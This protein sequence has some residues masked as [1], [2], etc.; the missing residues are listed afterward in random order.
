MRDILIVEDDGVFAEILKNFLE[1]QRYHCFVAK[2]LKAA[3]QRLRSTAA[4]LILLDLNLPDGNGLDFLFDLSKPGSQQCKVVVMTSFNDVR[5]AVQALKSGAYE[6]I[7]KPVNPDELLMIVEELKTETSTGN[8]QA[9]SSTPFITG[10][11]ESSR[12]M[13]T[14]IRL[15]AQ[16]NLTVLLEGKS[17]T[18]KEKAAQQIHQLSKRANR[19]FVAVDCGVLNAETANSE[20]FGHLKGS[21]TGAIQDKI[22]HIQYADGGTLFLDEIGNLSY[23]VQVK[24][25]RALQERVIQPMGSNKPHKVDLRIIA[26][27]NEDLRKAINRGEFREDLYHRINEFKIAV[28]S[29]SERKEDLAMLI[30]YFIGQGNRELNKSVRGITDEVKRLF[31]QYTWPG[32]IREL[33]SIIKRAVLLSQKNTIT[34]EELPPEM[35]LVVEQENICA[36]TSTDLKSQTHKLEKELL[37][38]TLERVNYNKSKAARIL[39]IDRSTVY[40]KLAAFKMDQTGRKI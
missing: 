37:I 2:S 39:K 14:H 11:S 3:R 25:L 15:V 19:P 22:G 34:L 29:L 38:E 31:Y 27:T 8:A 5:T 30:E 33:R 24:L 28:P 23:E 1:K 18:G 6:Y 35:A 40:K 10:P 4:D 20:L 32:N 21:F 17:G 36:G 16:T 7:T 13:M 9:H 26:A 12:Q